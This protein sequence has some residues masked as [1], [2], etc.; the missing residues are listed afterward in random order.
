[1]P[2]LSEEQL[3]LCYSEFRKH[4]IQMHDLEEWD[5]NAHMRLDLVH[6]TLM[7][8]QETQTLPVLPHP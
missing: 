3:G 7:L 2:D 1:M 4:C 5:T 6:W 8:L